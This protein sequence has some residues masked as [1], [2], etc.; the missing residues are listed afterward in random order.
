[1][2]AHNIRVRSNNSVRERQKTLNNRLVARFLT[3]TV[4]EED[5]GEKKQTKKNSLKKKKYVPV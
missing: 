2:G 5:T 4:Q 3:K 1:M